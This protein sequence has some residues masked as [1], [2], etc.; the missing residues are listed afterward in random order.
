MW[1]QTMGILYGPNDK[2]SRIMMLTFIKI[3]IS[4]DIVKNLLYSTRNVVALRK[5]FLVVKHIRKDG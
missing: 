5:A 4:N 2:A 3:Y 1:L